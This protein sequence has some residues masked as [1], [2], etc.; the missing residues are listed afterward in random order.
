[1]SMLR[2][3]KKHLE[4]GTAV[5]QSSN[6]QET[7]QRSKEYRLEHVPKVYYKDGGNFRRDNIK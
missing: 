5:G 1:M 3:N 7:T 4:A 6:D 2:K